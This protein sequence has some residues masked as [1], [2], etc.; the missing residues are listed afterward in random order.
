MQTAKQTLKGVWE[1]SKIW[2]L[3]FPKFPRVFALGYVSTKLPYSIS[4]YKIKPIQFYVT[5]YPC[6]HKLAQSDYSTNQSARYMNEIYIPNRNVF[7]VSI[8]L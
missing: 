4:S 5:S 1:N 3:N 7:P 8:E 6:L 2:L